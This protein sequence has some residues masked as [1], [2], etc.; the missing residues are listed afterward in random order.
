MPGSYGSLVKAAERL[1]LP[2]EIAAPA[3]IKTPAK[4]WLAASHAVPSMES[5]GLARQTTP[6]S[7]GETE[8]LARLQR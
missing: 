8:G 5:L 1:T 4:I 2:D 3:Q 6:F 7:G